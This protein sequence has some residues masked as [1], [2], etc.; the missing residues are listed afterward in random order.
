[1]RY[2]NSPRRVLQEQ[3]WRGQDDHAPDGRGYGPGVRAKAQTRDALNT[4][5]E[6]GGVCLS[7]RMSLESR[8]FRIRSGWT[9]RLGIC[10]AA[11]A[12]QHLDQILVRRGTNDHI[13]PD[14]SRRVR[15]E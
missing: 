15:A 5:S 14:S 13:A 4:R 1:M 11:G 6:A 12:L 8:V 3:H 9:P 7:L 2:V 10:L